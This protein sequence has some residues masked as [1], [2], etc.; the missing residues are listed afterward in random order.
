MINQAPGFKALAVAMRILVTAGGTRSYLDPVRWFG[1]VS[2]GKFGREIA[3]QC[4]ARGMEV[5]HLHA[6]DAPTV[7]Q[8]VVDIRNGPDAM[9]HTLDAVLESESWWNRY[10]SIEFDN[11]QGYAQQLEGLLR[12]ERIDIVF[13]AAAVADYAPAPQTGKITSDADELVVRMHRTPKLIAQVKEW[14]PG[15]FQVGFKLA[16]G[17]AERE[18]IEAARESGRRYRSDVT[19]AND[20]ALLA[21]GRH[22]IHLIRDGEPVETYGPP[23]N[24]AARLV[25]RVMHWYQTRRGG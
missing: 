14:S 21:A 20:L 25:E 7:W 8:R 23:E 22:T 17:V 5:V 9:M 10:R 12:G 19:V 13:L 15:T 24:V 18:L 11:W 4:L 1:N 2:R 6:A 3:R 16:A